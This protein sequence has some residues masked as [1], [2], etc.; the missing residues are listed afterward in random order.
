[1]ALVKGW[2]DFSIKLFFKWVNHEVQ[3]LYPNCQQK[4]QQILLNPSYWHFQIFNCGVK[5]MSFLGQKFGHSCRASGF[6]VG[7]STSCAQNCPTTDF[8]PISLIFLNKVLVQRSIQITFAYCYRSPDYRRRKRIK[9]QSSADVNQYR[10]KKKNCNWKS[11]PEKI[12]NTEE[13][14]Q[15]GRKNW[16]D[17]WL[18]GDQVCFEF[19]WSPSTSCPRL[20][21]KSTRYLRLK[22]CLDHYLPAKLM[23]L[24]FSQIAPFSRILL[25]WDDLL[26]NQLNLCTVWSSRDWLSETRRPNKICRLSSLPIFRSRMK[27]RSYFRFSTTLCPS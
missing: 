11:E 27:T 10:K 4:C 23:G 25:T 12:Y 5:I 6:K 2:W 26:G 22:S 7:W 9:P 3:D 16:Q 8:H 18:E 14:F 1:M 24:I 13:D 20:K 17:S 21:K 15:D 19:V